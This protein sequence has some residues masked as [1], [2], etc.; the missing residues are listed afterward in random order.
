MQPLSQTTTAAGEELC[1]LSPHPSFAR[2]S[3]PLGIEDQMSAKSN[4]LKHI[5]DLREKIRHHEYC[6]YVLDNPEISDAQFDQLMNQLKSLEQEHP[7]FITPDSP[8]QRVGGAP[9]KELPP[10]KHRVA[11][12]SLDN[13]YSY[14]ELRDFD[15][16]V[17]DVS[18]REKEQYIVEHKLD[19]LSFSLH[20]KDG[21]LAHGVTRGDGVTG[22]EVTA[23][24][25]TI[26]SIPLRLKIQGK[27]FA[28]LEVR[29]EVFMTKPVFEKV[30]EEREET[31]EPRF[32]NPRNAA[33]GTLRMLDSRIVAQRKLE[34]N[35]YAMLVKGEAPFATH[36]EVLKALQRLEFKVNPNWRICQ[37]LD[38]VIQFC[39]QWESRRDSLDYEIDG[40]VVKVDSISLQNELGATSKFP[41]WAVAYKFPARQAT[42]R[43]RDI[44]VQVGRTGAL[45]P[46]ADLEPVPLTGVTISRATLHNEDEI[47]RLGLRIGDTVLVERGGE[48]IPKIVKVLESKRPGDARIFV[49]P[50]KC[51]VCGGA[52]YRPEGE[53]IRR[54]VN[55]A[56]PA[57]LKEALLHFASRKAMDIDGLGDALVGQLVEQKC[58]HDF[59]DL[60]S[61]EV[62]RVA[63]LE[64][65]AQKSA[66]N[67]VEAIQESRKQSLARLIFALGIRFVGERTAQI[68]AN[69]FGSLDQLRQAKQDE[70]ENVFEVG[71]KVAAS[72]AQFFGVPQNLKI[73][74]KLR[75]HGLN[76][77]QSSG[78]LRSD[79]LQG[80]QFV[81]TGTLEHYTR[82]EA[83]AMIEGAGGVV[84][85][86]VSRKTDYVLAGT[87][88]G[89]KLGKAQQLG[90]PI[91]SEKDFL[92]ML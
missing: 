86:S 47:E 16:R 64:R 41:R 73:V 6:Y 48:V 28:E 79:R 89:S 59:A 77:K 83:K 68:L 37:S 78:P 61:L 26:R 21:I 62:D 8:T 7:E 70:L 15:R 71:P 30:N 23:N 88:P 13:C 87:Q 18:G 35:A 19:G 56:C 25:K 29:G 11:M 66:R 33:A 5:S 43:V 51:P 82:E 34:A 90:V 39:E 3:L 36:A 24:I 12:L 67:L 65:M 49:P 38:E 14:E 74:E 53:V 75:T 46:V 84:T 10:F 27:E 72:I 32:A 17:R 50:R 76:F 22:E 63:T 2:I 40:I 91:I 54:C 20:Y 92:K 85:S 44:L 4:L 1:S 80:N 69:H 60:Y 52:V 45:T 55:A 9:A 42:T 31:G 58:V 81:L 57:K